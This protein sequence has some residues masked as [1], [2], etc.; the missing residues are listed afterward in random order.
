[1]T[2]GA[3]HQQLL[4]PFFSYDDKWCNSSQWT[5]KKGQQLKQ[6]NNKRIRKVY[7][8][9]IQT[10]SIHNQDNLVMVQGLTIGYQW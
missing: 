2:A 8:Y 3:K 1:M 5:I 6:K 10:I 7:R 4:G 9:K